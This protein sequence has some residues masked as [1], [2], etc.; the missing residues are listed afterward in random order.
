MALT[1]NTRVTRPRIEGLTQ[2]AGDFN[3]PATQVKSV[4]LVVDSTSTIGTLS[5][6]ATAEDNSNATAG[7]LDASPGLIYTGTPG[8]FVNVE[9]Y[10]FDVKASLTSATL[11]ESVAYAP[12][13]EAGEIAAVPATEDTVSA[14][15]FINSA[16]AGSCD[17]GSVGEMDTVTAEFNINTH[18]GPLTSGD[19]IRLG[20]VWTGE[21]DAD[22]TLPSAGQVIIT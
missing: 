9:I 14:A 16:V 11:P 3:C 1:N 5:Y 15:I 6:S 21:T 13:V 19:V 2:P 8:G 4:G 7:D 12:F 10:D 22:L 18:V 17:E 20:I